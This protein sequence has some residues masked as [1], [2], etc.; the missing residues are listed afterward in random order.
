MFKINDAFAPSLACLIIFL[1]PSHPESIKK[2]F[3]RR[4]LNLGEKS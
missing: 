4:E 1:A 3:E 2:V